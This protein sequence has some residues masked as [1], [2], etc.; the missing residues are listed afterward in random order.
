MKKGCLLGMLLGLVLSVTAC[1]SVSV[2]TLEEVSGYCPPDYAT[3]SGDSD[4]DVF[5]TFCGED[6]IC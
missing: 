6:F 2:P 1:G 3:N 5:G 4:V